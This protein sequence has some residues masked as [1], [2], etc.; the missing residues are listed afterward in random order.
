MNED[1]LQY[2][3]KYQRFTSHNLTCRDGQNLEV[4]KTGTHN[5]NAGP[6]FLDARLR[7]GDTVWAGNVEI[8]INSSDWYKHNHDK[9]KAYENVI[10]HVVFTNDTPVLDKSGQEIPV[11]V[12]KDL[13]D[14][15]IF[16]YY[17][18]WVKKASFIPCEELVVNVPDIVKTAAVQSEAI[19]RLEIKSEQCSDLLNQTNGDIEEAFYQILCRSLG[20]S[21]NA[22]PFENLALNTPF[23]L[24]RKNKSSV[25]EMEALLLG[26]AG[27]L[28]DDTEQNAY[29][30]KLKS[31]Y[32]HQKLKYKLQPMPKTAWKYSRLRPQ[33]FPAVRIAQLAQIYFNNGALAQKIIEQKSIRGI[34]EIFDVSLKT[35][36]WKTHYTLKTSSEAVIKSLGKSTID[37]LIVNAIVPFLFALASYN[38]DHSFRERAI[39]F[40]EELPS[41]KNAVISKFA[42]LDLLSRSAL[43][44]QGLIGLKK[45]R[46]EKLKCLNCKIGIYILKQNGTIH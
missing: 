1:F 42:K 15:Q 29:L 28:D 2:V 23:S 3:W 17:K 8:H 39:D 16:R 31:E 38:K 27:L 5:F 14:Y 26:Q 11:L 6:D 21:V 41:E 43:D 36:F 32:A 24:L 4:I 40:L 20:L 22:M 18:S 12:L 46:C 45:N 9:D 34:E 33:N 25:F 10:L 7:I 44:S 19:N 13:L 35:P 37:L 30:D